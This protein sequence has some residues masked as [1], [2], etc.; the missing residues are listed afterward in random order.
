MIQPEIKI[1]AWE[2]R[3]TKRFRSQQNFHIKSIKRESGKRRVP[4]PPLLSVYSS[5]LARA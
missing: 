2:S 4:E 1:T 3:A 5:L